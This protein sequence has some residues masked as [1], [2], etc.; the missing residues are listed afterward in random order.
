MP[1]GADSYSHVT[2][3]DQRDDDT[4][5]I[6]VQTTSFT[7]GQ[8]VEV[9]VYL[10]QGDTYAAFNDKKHIPLP[11]PNDPKQ[12]AMLHVQLPVT[13]LNADADVTVVTRVS[14]VWPTLLEP[15]REIPANYKLQGV[16]GPK[17]V[18]TAQYPSGKGS[19]DQASPPP[20][21]GGGGATPTPH[22]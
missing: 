14:E 6:H 4:V 13:A 19:G 9:S 5:E 2:R 12:P 16:T 18:W 17:A 10:L 21:N 11:D 15:N 20:G 1:N 22:Q 7:P 8:E 3:I